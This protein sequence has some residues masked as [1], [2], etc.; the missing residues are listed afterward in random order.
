MLEFPKPVMK[1][2]ELQK[3]GFPETYLK[4]AYGDKNHKDESG[5]NKKSGYFRHRWLQNL[6][7]KAD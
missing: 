3:M 1:M 4:R 6:V 5:I 7:G 2:S